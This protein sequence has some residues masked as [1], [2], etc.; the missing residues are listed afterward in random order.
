[1]GIE[2]K[3]LMEAEEAFKLD[4]VRVKLVKETPLYSELEY[5]QSPDQC[6]CG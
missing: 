2:K 6:G 4:V 1:M 3:P 5:L